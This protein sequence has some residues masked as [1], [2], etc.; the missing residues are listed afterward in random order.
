VLAVELLDSKKDTK[1]TRF[2]RRIIC[3]N[4]KIDYLKEEREEK[5]ERD[6]KKKMLEN[7]TG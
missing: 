7:G 5:R 4:K 1:F 6:H 3:G 2:L